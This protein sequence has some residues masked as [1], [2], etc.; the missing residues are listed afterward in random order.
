[1]GFSFLFLFYFF[2]SLSLSHTHTRIH[3]LLDSHS[4]FKA[5]KENYVRK[6][7]K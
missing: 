6:G 1:M 5:I 3:T 2:L 4:H 7:K